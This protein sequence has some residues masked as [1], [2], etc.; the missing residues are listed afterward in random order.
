VSNNNII[1]KKNNDHDYDHNHRRR[2]RRTTTTTSSAALPS[3]NVTNVMGASAVPIWSQD[4][5]RIRKTQIQKVSKVPTA[6]TPGTQ[7]LGSVLPC[8]LKSNVQNHAHS[9]QHPL[10]G[11]RLGAQL[12][13]ED[14][15]RTTRGDAVSGADV[16]VLVRLV[17]GHA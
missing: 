4:V 7:I 5:A 12:R 8:A 14:E 15:V 13:C 17:G 11:R 1:N 16:D 2:R 6:A 9:C 10:V 3:S